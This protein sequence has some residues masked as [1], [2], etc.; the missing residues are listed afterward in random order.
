MNHEEI[1]AAACRTRARKKIPDVSVSTTSP[2]AQLD[3]DS[4]LMLNAIE[5]ETGDQ[6]AKF[7]F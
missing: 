4:F 6:A 5:D 3:V 7:L 1:K 2:A